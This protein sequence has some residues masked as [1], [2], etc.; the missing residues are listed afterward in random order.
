MNE[1]VTPLTPIIMQIKNKWRSTAKTSISYQSVAEQARQGF[2][3]SSLLT[4][5]MPSVFEQVQ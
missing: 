2:R 1:G 3:H 4:K 5:K